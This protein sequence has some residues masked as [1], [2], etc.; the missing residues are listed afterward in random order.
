ARGLVNCRDELVRSVRVHNRRAANLV[1]HANIADNVPRKSH[2][3]RTHKFPCAR[4]LWHSPKNATVRLRTK[5]IL[6]SPAGNLHHFEQERQFIKLQN[7]PVNV[8]SN[9]AWNLRKP[10]KRG[11]LP[12]HVHEVKGRDKPIPKLFATSNHRQGLTL[13][14][15]LGSVQPFPIPNR[16]IQGPKIDGRDVPRALRNKLSPRRIE[17]QFWHNPGV[18]KVQKYCL[19][20]DIRHRDKRLAKISLARRGIRWILVSNCLSF[21]WQMP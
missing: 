16:G 21:T 3:T 1:V 18:G 6:E 14:A 13:Q 12:Y 4:V 10:E 7:T 2:P 20:V 8:V 11:R 19:A 5:R 15:S 17:C 9:V